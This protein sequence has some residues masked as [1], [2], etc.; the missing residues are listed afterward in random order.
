MDFNMPLP[1]T[2]VS[3]YILFKYVCSVAV[4][5]MEN[6]IGVLSSNSN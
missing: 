2:E 3:K 5:G 1:P 4:I 6:G